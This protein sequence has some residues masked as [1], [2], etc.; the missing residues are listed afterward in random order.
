MKKL[1]LTE[2][3]PGLNQ[4]VIKQKDLETRSGKIPIARLPVGSY[5][6]GIKADVDQPFTASAVSSTVPASVLGTDINTYSTSYRF[7]IGTSSN[8]DHFMEEINPTTEGEYGINSGEYFD[9]PTMF[10]VPYTI[11]L[12][13]SIIP[14]TWTFGGDLNTAR[15]VLGGCGTQTAGLSFGGRDVLGATS[16][17]T[18][19]YDGASW[20]ASN[21]L[22][23]ARWGLGGVGTQS[24]GLS[25]GGSVTLTTTEEYD[26]TSWAAANGLNTGRRGVIGCGTQTAGLS[27]GGYDTYMSVTEEYDGTSWAASN[28]L[29]RA[30]SWMAG[31]GTQTA[32]LGIGGNTAA[33]AIYDTEEYN[34]SNWSVGNDLNIPRKNCGGCGIQ[35][36][37]LSFGGNGDN[38]LGSTE[39]YNG[40]VWVFSNNMNLIKLYLASSGTQTAGLCFGGENNETVK[41]PITEEYNEID[42]TSVAINGMMTLSFLVY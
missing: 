25:F 26:G 8:K 17:G 11:Y 36:A 3:V 31:C 20:T 37:G 42:I 38:V 2:L 35:S 13:S 33:G 41:I 12:D 4:I 5:L 29:N 30:K 40:S 32:A 19:E 7:K 21:N 10:D 27:F 16:S 6:Y 24:A 18:E 34:G 14:R 23:T 39:E 22:N 1:N 28:D 15:D 9:D